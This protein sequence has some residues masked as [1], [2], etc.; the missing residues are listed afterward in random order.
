MGNYRHDDQ[1]RNW[2]AELLPYDNL[3]VAGSDTTY[4]ELSPSTRLILL[5]LV[6]VAHWTTRYYSDTDQQID[7]GT[8]EWMAS[9]A[10]FELMRELDMDC[11]NDILVKLDQLSSMI[12]NQQMVAGESS[13]SDVD[14]AYDGTTGSIAP[15]A[16][17]DG[18]GADNNRDTALCYALHSTIA[19]VLD[20]IASDKENWQKEVAMVAGATASLGI[21]LAGF[22]A[23]LSALVATAIAG[24]IS[25]VSQAIIASINEDELRDEDAR[26]IVLCHAY[27]NLEGATPTI[28]TLAASFDGDL[29]GFDPI[30]EKQRQVLSAVASD[31]DFY[32]SFV[33][34]MNEGVELD[35]NIGLDNYCSQCGLWQEDWLGGNG[36]PAADGWSFDSGVYNSGND[37]YD[38]QD[39]GGSTTWI[40]ANYVISDATTINDITISL[41]GQTSGVQSRSILVRIY[42][43]TDTE[44]HKESTSWVEGTRTLSLTGTFAVLPGWRLNF[45]MGI[46]GNESQ[47]DLELRSLSVAGDGDNPWG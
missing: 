3:I 25:L 9:Q 6:R 24:G 30:A 21:T 47:A 10:E 42:D 33:K 38:G 16:V 34:I 26:D 37:Y 18:S 13:L 46:S 43:D 8:V 7:K 35:Q 17:Y 19:A 31:V 12:G 32:Y 40:A 27:E 2:K 28:T 44:Q 1:K 45:Y 15:N 4:H 22:T 14:D 11:C 39:G 23:G 20:A 29:S 36:D 5:A 41:W